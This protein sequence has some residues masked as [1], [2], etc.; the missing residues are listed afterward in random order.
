MKILFAASEIYPLIKTGGLADV[1]GALPVALRKKGHDVKLI[2]P[3]YQGIL[4]KVA[5][6]QKRINLGNPF[7]VGDLLLLESHIPA[8]DT[9]IWL[10]QC[11]ALYEREDG[12]YVDKRG[13]DFADNHIRFAALSW[14]AATLAANGSLIDWQADI[15]HLNDWQTGFAAAYLESWKTEHIPVV[16]TVHNL[17]YNGS[18][19]MDQFPATHLSPELLSMHGMEFYG[20][21]SGLKAGLVYADAVTTVSPTYAQEILTPEYGDGLDGTLRA[22]QDKLSGI[23]NGVDYD[24]WSPEKDTLI[25]HRY[26]QNSLD[27]KR[28]NKLALLK[29]NNLSED[30]EQPLFGVISRLTEQKGLDLILE[31]MP[32]MLEKGARLIVLGSGDKN[33]ESG[34][35]ELQKNYPDQVSVRIGYFEDY[36]HRIQ[37]GIDALLIPSRFEPCGLTQLYALKYG[38]LPVVRKTGGLAD[39]VFEEG[40]RQNGFVFKEASVHSLQEAMERCIACFYDQQSWQERQKNAMSYDYSWEAVTDQWIDLYQTLLSK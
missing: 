18:F 20:R 21:F 4:E 26:N 9:P 28:L 2:M 11:Q 40:N 37:A 12:P 31:A 8:N 25:P 10:L 1:A 5:P 39:T 13:V 23:L 36:S 14:A 33:L 15:L 16:T 32:A 29:E 34:Y 17:R 7:G 19:D 27:Q 38:T 22:M 24:Q 30:V 6:I 3:A 35:L